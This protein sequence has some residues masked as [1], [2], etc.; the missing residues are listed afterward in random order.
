MIACTFTDGGAVSSLLWAILGL[1][2]GLPLG[3]PGLIGGPVA[4]FM[5]SAARTRS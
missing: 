4:Y 3:L 2:F 1:V 5:G